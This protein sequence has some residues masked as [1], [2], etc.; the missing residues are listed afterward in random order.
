MSIPDAMSRG[1]GR[2]LYIWFLLYL[3]SMILI[4]LPIYLWQKAEAYFEPPR[5]TIVTAIG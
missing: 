2:G 5:A 4:A 3:W 1:V